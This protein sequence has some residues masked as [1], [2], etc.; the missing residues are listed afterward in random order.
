MKAAGVGI[1]SGF[2]AVLGYKGYEQYESGQEGKFLDTNFWNLVRTNP[3]QSL[4]EDI[5]EVIPHNKFVQKDIQRVS[6]RLAEGFSANTLVSIQNRSELY[7]N[8]RLYNLDGILSDVGWSGFASIPTVQIAEGKPGYE[9]V[10]NLVVDDKDSLRIKDVLPLSLM[11]AD[12]RVY[13]AGKSENLFFQNEIM[14]KN[15]GVKSS[16]IMVSGLSVLALAE[17]DMSFFNLSNVFAHA[18]NEWVIQGKDGIKPVEISGSL[19]ILVDLAE[20]MAVDMGL[21]Y[22]QMVELYKTSDLSTLMQKLLVKR[23]VDLTKRY[24]DD[25]ETE[26]AAVGISF[27]NLSSFIEEYVL[28]APA[29]NNLGKAYEDFMNY[30]ANNMVPHLDGE[31]KLPAGMDETAYFAKRHRGNFPA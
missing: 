4:E 22:D 8:S 1:G 13:E 18:F 5:F 3:G 7:S 2:L 27:L 16:M 29:F 23:N 14:E 10:H 26:R 25:S 9:L 11:Q 31:N 12:V 20:R 6:E 15:Y 28:Q 19:D 21:T 17:E 24:Q 30:F